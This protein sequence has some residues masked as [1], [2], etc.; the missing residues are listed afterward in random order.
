MSLWR[1]L[2]GWGGGFPTLR[3]LIHT[4]CFTHN[5]SCGQLDKEK[6]G[7]V[8]T[9]SSKERDMHNS[10]QFS[11]GRT[12]SVISTW[13]YCIFHPSGTYSNKA[14]I[15]P[16]IL[17]T[18]MSWPSLLKDGFLHRIQGSRGSHR[19][20][21]GQRRACWPKREP[22]GS[23]HRA[24]LHRSTGSSADS[25]GSSQLLSEVTPG[26]QLHYP[27][28]LQFS[29][30]N[31]TASFI[32]TTINKPTEQQHQI[33]VKQLLFAHETC[34]RVSVMVNYCITL[35]FHVQ[36]WSYIAGWQ[37]VFCLSPSLKL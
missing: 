31:E 32:S 24:R 16:W 26:G 27:M 4:G 23:L 29:L 18:R 3:Y 7:D 8:I 12:Y 28:L 2:A 30:S 9:V 33:T 20:D 5:W 35:N 34:G 15:T 1:F 17:P 10:L 13:L 22:E 11:E 25:G 21:R 6:Y 14:E 36:F 19:G 37:C